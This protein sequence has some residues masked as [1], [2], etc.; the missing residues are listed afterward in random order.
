MPEDKE[1][2]PAPE[3]ETGTNADRQVPDKASV[4]IRYEKEQIHDRA[5]Q[6]SVRPDER[7]EIIQDTGGG[8]TSGGDQSPSDNE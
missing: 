2:Q 1:A 6:V 7:D 3:R 4:D 5:G 8:D